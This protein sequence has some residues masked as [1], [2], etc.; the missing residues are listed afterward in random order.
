MPAA[1][2]GLML[3]NRKDLLASYGLGRSAISNHLKGQAVCGAIIDGRYESM[4]NPRVWGDGDPEGVRQRG[5]GDEDH[6]SGRSLVRRP[7]RGR[8]HWF[9]DL[10]LRG[11][12]SAGRRC[13]DVELASIGQ[14]AKA[15]QDHH[16]R[17]RFLPRRGGEGHR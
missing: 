17:M 14:L 13:T 3:Q 1:G 7:H 12:V 16:W 11:E 8:F 6:G 5:R 10:A 9:G 15:V 4:V 2:V